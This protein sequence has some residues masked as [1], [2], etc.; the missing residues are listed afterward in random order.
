MKRILSV[1]SVFLLACV[2][3]A[4]FSVVTADNANADLISCFGPQSYYV[5]SCDTGP[6][7]PNPNWPYYVYHCDD[8]L[9]CGCVWEW[10]HSDWQGNCD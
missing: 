2:I 8:Q 3:S 6:K 5:F 7:C 1:F 9:G 4:G 10:C